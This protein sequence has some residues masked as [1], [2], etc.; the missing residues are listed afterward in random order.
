MRKKIKGGT[1]NLILGIT[2][3]FIFWAFGYFSYEF[4]GWSR[5]VYAIILLI[6]MPIPWSQLVLYAM[7][8]RTIGHIIADKINKKNTDKDTDLK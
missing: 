4:L 6:L 2:F 7:G 5:T 3:T 8:K 1:I